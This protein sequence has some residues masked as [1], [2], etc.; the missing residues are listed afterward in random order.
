MISKN[1]V[2]KRWSCLMLGRDWQIKL[3]QSVDTETAMCDSSDII[4]QLAD[5]WTQRTYTTKQN[6]G[7]RKLIFTTVQYY[8][9]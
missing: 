1:I 6:D 7:P 3:M 5:I 2:E 8:V 4:N 9:L